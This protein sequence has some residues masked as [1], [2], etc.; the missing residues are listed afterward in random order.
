[1]QLDLTNKL[2]KDKSY[3]F[4]KQVEYLKRFQEQ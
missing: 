4:N 1:M 2:D 3:F